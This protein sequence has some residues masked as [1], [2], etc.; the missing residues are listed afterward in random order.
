MS[1]AYDH[2]LEGLR[3]CATPLG[4]KAGALTTGY[5]QVRARD[6]GITARTCVETGFSFSE[7]ASLF[8][9]GRTR[10]GG[11]PDTHLVCT[12]QLGGYVTCCCSRLQTKRGVMRLVAVF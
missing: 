7:A 12:V 11:A 10:S 5:P 6:S 1:T 8:Y 2:A 3:E 4:F 9:E